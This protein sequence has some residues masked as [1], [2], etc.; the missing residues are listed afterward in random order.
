M[1]NVLLQI[2]VPTKNYSGPFVAGPFV[3]P[4]GAAVVRTSLSGLSTADYENAANAI[5]AGLYLSADGGATYPPD[6]YCGFRWQG[7]RTVG[8]SGAVDPQ[9]VQGDCGLD[10]SHRGA[11]AKV[12][13]TVTG[14]VRFG[15]TVTVYDGLP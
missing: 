1:A 10:P 2:T 7:G 9:P 11:T 8:K 14:N 12:A 4:A 5:D 15:G 3:V 13:G 6:A